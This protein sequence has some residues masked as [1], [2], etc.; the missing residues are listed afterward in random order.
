MILLKCLLRT[1]VTLCTVFLSLFL[2][3]CGG[4]SSNNSDS[5]A[6]SSSGGGTVGSGSS[7]TPSPSPEVTAAPT[8]T[9][10]SA[11]SPTSSPMPSP[12]PTATPS[13]PTLQA[14]ELRDPNPS[15]SIEFSPSLT[16]LANGNIVLTKPEDSPNGINK[17]GSVHIYN[18]NTQAIIASIE[19]DNENDLLG[20]SGIDVLDNGNFF[21]RSHLDNVDGVQQAGSI[22]LID[23]DTGVQIGDTIHG[24]KTNDR[25]GTELVY[26]LSDNN[27][28]VL[29]GKD[30]P[31]SG[32]TDTGSIRVLNGETG[33]ERSA[34]YYGAASDDLSLARVVR[35]TNGNIA[36]IAPNADNGTVKNTGA[37]L[38]FNA[39]GEPVAEPLYGNN[40]GSK[41]GS[42]GYKALS[43]GNIVVVSIIDT[44]AGPAGTSSIRLVSGTT[45]TFIGDPLVENI[46]A[47]RESRITALPNDNYVV[48]LPNN[49]ISSVTHAGSVKLVSGKD[50]TVIG[51][52]ISGTTTSDRLGSSGVRALANSNYIIASSEHNISGN[53]DAGS[54]ML[55]NGTNGEIVGKP[56]EGASEGDRIGFY[57]AVLSNGNVMIASPHVDVGALVDSGQVILINGASGATVGEA[58][59][60]GA[61]NSQFA[62]QGLRV[63]DNGN[64]LVSSSKGRL[65]NNG[66]VAL[67][68]GA[69]N[70][71]ISSVMDAGLAGGNIETVDT[72]ELSDNR[73]LF[74]T[75]STDI[76]GGND[77][78]GIFNYNGDN[79]TLVH[80]P[81]FGENPN[82]FA[83]SSFAKTQDNSFF[84]LALP[85]AENYGVEE[86]GKFLVFRP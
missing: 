41:I 74:V 3:G 35:L 16:I 77:V 59:I 51:S 75:P 71:F 1:R 26:Q 30:Q 24:N 48:A 4:S 61:N 54:V 53:S 18:S 13:L 31:A 14:V 27:A 17:A 56:I 55:V 76:S 80:Q 37:V 9:P 23:G 33:V 69:T 21:I 84:V 58:L 68:D 39:M 36:I 85:Q 72:Y 63:L 81:I 62:D 79:G 83:N 78:G 8:P 19:G 2:S 66:E 25:F 20:S 10:T 32:A 52:P 67:I 45:N 82:D 86:A 47:I 57:T 64:V 44:V 73:I 6:G 28:L 11:P 40:A 34:I 5:G 15:K 43:N 29:I 42:N 12:E 38:L 49:D 65:R 70:T 46:N 22:R 7:P 50:N 60:G